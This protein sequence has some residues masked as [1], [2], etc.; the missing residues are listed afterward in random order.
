MGEEF[1]GHGLLPNVESL[2]RDCVRNQTGQ[3]IGSSCDQSSAI[4]AGSILCVGAPLWCLPG[5]F[6]RPTRGAVCLPVSRDRVAASRMDR[7]PKAS[8]ESV[9]GGMPV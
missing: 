5:R 3:L 2:A 4:R 8:A 1:P 9:L 6:F 7:T